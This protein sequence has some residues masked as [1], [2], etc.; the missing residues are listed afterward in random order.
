M[1]I[2][3]ENIYKSFRLHYSHSKIGKDPFPQIFMVCFHVSTLY[4][5]IVYYLFRKRFVFLHKEVI[6]Y[7]LW[8]DGKSS[9]L[10]QNNIL[11]M[12]F[13]LNYKVLF[14]QTVFQA[15]RSDIVSAYFR[16]APFQGTQDTNKT[17]RPWTHSTCSVKTWP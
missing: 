13:T 1:H 16:M 12:S 3:H 8:R 5:Q 11:S 7:L 9:A 10:M 4:Y 6:F 15:S 2:S 14:P 17:D